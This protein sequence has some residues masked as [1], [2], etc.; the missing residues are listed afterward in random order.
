MESGFLNLPIT[1]ETSL[2]FV[3]DLKTTDPYA[4]SVLSNVN[5][6]YEGDFNTAPNL[7]TF[8][9]HNTGSSTSDNTPSL[10]FNLTDP[11]GGDLV[12][13][14][15]QVDNN[16]DFSSPLIDFTETNYTVSPRNNVV[17]NSSILSD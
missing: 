4:T 17:Y 15:I 12:K 5:I 6:S 13:Y 10:S 3:F 16:A 2:D 9:S 8:N 14:Q 7:T 1:T 11:D